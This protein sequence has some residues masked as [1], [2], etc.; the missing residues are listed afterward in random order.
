MTFVQLTL[1]PNVLPGALTQ[2]GAVGRLEAGSVV[3]TEPFTFTVL[4]LVS[5]VF[6]RAATGRLVADIDRAVAAIKAVVLTSEA[7]AVGSC[8]AL[9][10]SAGRGT[11]VRGGAGASVLAVVPALVDLTSLSG[12]AG[13]AATLGHLTGVEETAPPIQT[14]NIAGA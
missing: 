2:L 6:W 5:V 7:V 9:W 11:C 3:F 4:A 1:V 10:A 14:L 13:L 8:E 12:V